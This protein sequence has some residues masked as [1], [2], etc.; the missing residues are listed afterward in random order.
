MQMSEVA[1]KGFGVHEKR[2]TSLAAPILADAN[3]L[4]IM[5]QGIILVWC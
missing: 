5:Q 3:F 1:E 2:V 4:N